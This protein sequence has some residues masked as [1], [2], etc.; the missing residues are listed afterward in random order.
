MKPRNSVRVRREVARIMAKF[1]VLVKQ[2]REV[3]DEMEDPR[4]NRTLATAGGAVPVVR[5]AEG[6]NR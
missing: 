5:M 3:H 4:Q 2:L 1:D 6:G